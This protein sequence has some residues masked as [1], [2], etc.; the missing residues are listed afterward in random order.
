MIS[1]SERLKRLEA[2][3]PDSLILLCDNNGEEIKCTV[4]ELEN[5]PDMKLIKVIG[6]NSVSDVK[7]ILKYIDEL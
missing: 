5:N 3:K 4:K 7:K 6:G 2:G 1:L